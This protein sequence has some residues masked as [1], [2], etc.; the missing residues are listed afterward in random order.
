MSVYISQFISIGAYI[1]L[2]LGVAGM[3]LSYV[4]NLLSD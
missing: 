3:A 4:L 2:A 1:A